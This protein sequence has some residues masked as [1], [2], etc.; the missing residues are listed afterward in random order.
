VEKKK[1]FF[2]SNEYF[3]NLLPDISDSQSYDLSHELLSID[4][5][6]VN[7]INDYTKEILRS[8]IEFKE[9]MMMYKC[10]IKEIRTKF[11][12]LNTEFKIRYQRN[13]IKFIETRLKST[14]SIIEKMSRKN[15]PFSIENIE[16]YINDVAGIRVICSYVDD[17]YSIAKALIQQDDIKLIKQKDYI[18][19]PKPNGYRS[20]HLIVS[21]PVYFAEQKKHMK[22]EVQIRTIAM[23]FWASLEHQLRYKQQVAEETEIAEQL[24][25]CADL[26]SEVDSRMLGIRTKIEANSNEP[27]EEEILFEKLCKIDLQIE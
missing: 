6:L 27:T 10:A 18:A 20:L 19:H 25:E 17:I 13:P 9:L 2:D 24:K 16:N 4:G 11:D 1:D 5:T 21:V 8:V 3:G 14:S 23:D 15:I 22:V 12:V 26:I 7:T